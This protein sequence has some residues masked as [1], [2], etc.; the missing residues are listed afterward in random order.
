MKRLALLTVLLFAVLAFGIDGS[1]VNK[2]IAEGNANSIQVLPGN[3]RIALTSALSTSDAAIDAIQ[4]I[5]GQHRNRLKANFPVDNDPDSPFLTNLSGYWKLGEASGTRADSSVNGNDLTDNNTVTSATGI[6]GDCGHFVAANVEFLNRADNASLSV[7]G[8]DFSLQA[9]FKPTTDV[10]SP[11]VAKY[12]A[13]GASREYAIRVISTQFNVLI[14]Q[15][16]STQDSVTAG[17]PSN[18]VWSHLVFTW[19]NTTREGILYVDNSATAKSFAVTGNY[20]DNA[21]FV[22]GGWSSPG[23]GATQNGDIDEVGLWKRKLTASEVEDLYNAGSGVTYPTFA[24]NHFDQFI[25]KMC[26]YTANKK[27]NHADPNYR[28]L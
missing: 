4:V 18:G 14:G 17:A 22:I 13:D 7:G 8:S 19:D 16:D 28:F 21:D 23:A 10:N 11:I 27:K 12:P 24:L 9:W 1:N 3:V 26:G 2:I 15:D 25:L 6:Q 20:D 5:P